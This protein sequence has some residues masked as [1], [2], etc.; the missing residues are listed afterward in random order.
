MSD[1]I[2]R[3]AAI[4]AVNA[5]RKDDRFGLDEYQTGKNDEID[6]I[7]DIL[8]A[9]LPS[10]E[11]EQDYIKFKKGIKKSTQDDY[12]I[13]NRYWLY[14]HLDQEIDI[15][16]SVMKSMGYEKAEPQE[17]H[18][19]WNKTFEFHGFDDEVNREAIACSV[20]KVAFPGRY[21]WSVEDMLEDFR[22]CPNCG[23]RMDKY[24]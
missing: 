17:W 20:C 15:Q 22:Y 3:Q 6:Y 8:L 18:G 12:L 23:A 1:L 4:D 5:L 2:D 14:E 7:A 19:K 10:A 21:D 9:E 13:Y 24:D 16:K 11:P